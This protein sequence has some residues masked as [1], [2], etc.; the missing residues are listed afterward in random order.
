MKQ[1]KEDVYRVIKKIPRGKVATYK[2]VARAVGRPGAYRAVGNALN[3]NLRAPKVPCHRVVKSDGK[4]GGY[5]GGVKEKIKLLKK[6]GIQI[7]NNQINLKKFGFR[8]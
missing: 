3:K 5:A 4:I 2:A 7:K 6:E 1:F 8:F